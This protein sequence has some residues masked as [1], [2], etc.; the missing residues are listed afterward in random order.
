MKINDYRPCAPVQMTDAQ[1]ERQ[2]IQV[3][4]LRLAIAAQERRPLVEL[5]RA[6]LELWKERASCED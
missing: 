6:A 1:R 4:W 2:D 3:E 5:Q